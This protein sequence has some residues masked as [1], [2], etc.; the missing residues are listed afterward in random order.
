MIN[1]DCIVK[2]FEKPFP[3]IKIQNFLEKNFFENLEST[4]PDIK[5]FEAS[6]RS[7]SRMDYDITFGD[8]LYTKLLSE[9]SEYKK[10]HDYVYSSEF[11]RHFVDLFKESIKY[12][13]DNKFL[14]DDILNYQIVPEPFETGRVIG[15]K[16]FKNSNKKFLYPRLD[17]GVGIEGYGKNNGGGGSKVR[18]EVAC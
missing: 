11:I 1:K 4:F 18:P 16:E 5:D 10:F 8:S 13:F 9:N 14:T 6:E 3:Y 7:L 15:K 2:K 17:L 12:E